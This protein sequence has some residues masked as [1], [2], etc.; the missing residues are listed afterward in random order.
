MIAL[1]INVFAS[2]FRLLCDLENKIGLS[3]ARDP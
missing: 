2:A 1:R 3:G